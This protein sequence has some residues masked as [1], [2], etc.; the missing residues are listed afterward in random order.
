MTK[1]TFHYSKT[2][3]DDEA[4]MQ[5]MCAQGWAAVKLTEG[6]WTFEP[7]KPGQYCFRICYLRGKTKAEIR[8]LKQQFADKGIEFVSRYSFWAIFRSETPFELYSPKE[9]L[10]IC[11]QIYAPMPIGAAVSWLVFAVLLCF[12][13]KF[14]ALWSIPA[15]LVGIYAAMCT[16]LGLSYRRLLRQIS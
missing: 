5:K 11:K 6:F 12:C 14:G 3:R 4:Y 13:F 1:R 10:Q 8:A 16:W 9:E 2:H 15:V 7:C